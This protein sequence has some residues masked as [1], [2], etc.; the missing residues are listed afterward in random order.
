MCVD[1]KFR[2]EAIFH[3]LDYNF[4][5][6]LVGIIIHSMLILINH[7]IQFIFFSVHI[8]QILT[9]TLERDHE[10]RE[11]VNFKSQIFSILGRTRFETNIDEAT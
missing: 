5:F 4:R 1:E 3:L 10:Y 9:A 7:I 2:D 8:Y 6:C 11:N